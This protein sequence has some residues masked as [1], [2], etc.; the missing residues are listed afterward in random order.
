MRSWARSLAPWLACGT[1]ASC[2]PHATLAVEV[3]FDYEVSANRAEV[4]E[5]LRDGASGTVRRVPCSDDGACPQLASGEPAVRCVEGACD[6][7]PFVFVLSTDVIDLDMTPAVQRYG[8]RVTGIELVDARF[9]ASAN[10][11]RNPVGPTELFWGPASAVSIDAQGVHPIGTIPQI[12]LGEAPTVE[13]AVAL[14]AAGAAA[15]SDHLVGVSR[16]FRLFAR[17]RIDVAPAGPL[18]TGSIRLQVRMVVHV[19]GQLVR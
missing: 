15:L 13:D 16:R 18:P 4:P 8:G 19:R 17:P 12:A 1:L 7:E 2:D 3:P 9:V 6:P 10:G 14:D 5:A 11:L